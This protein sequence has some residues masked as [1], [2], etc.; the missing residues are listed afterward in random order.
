MTELFTFTITT[1]VDLGESPSLFTDKGEFVGRV[2]YG[3]R[4]D[5]DP[6]H[7][8]YTYD[9]ESD[10]NMFEQPSSGTAKLYDITD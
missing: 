9:I 8:F 3:R 10:K 7:I 1:T 6:N 2:L 5:L 4:N